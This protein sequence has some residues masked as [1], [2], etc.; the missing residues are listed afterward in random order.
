MSIRSEVSQVR[1]SCRDTS[2]LFLPVSMNTPEWCRWLLQGSNQKSRVNKQTC[3]SLRQAKRYSYVSS[4]TSSVT[5]EANFFNF[6]PKGQGKLGMFEASRT[7]IYGPL[8]NAMS[9]SL[10]RW[11]GAWKGS[12]NY[13]MDWRLEG[14]KQLF[15]GLAPGRVQTTIPW[16]GAWKGSNNYSMDWRLEGFKQLFHGIAPGR[17]QTTIPWTGAWKGS[18]NYSM[19][20]RLEGFKQLFHGLAPGR[21]QTTIP[22]TGAW[23]G[24]NNYSMDWRLEGFKQLFHGMAPGRVQ[25]TIPW[26][27]A[28][29]GSNNYSMDWRLE[30]FK[31]LFHGM[32]VWRCSIRS[33]KLKLEYITFS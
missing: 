28:W 5:D 7:K 18:N 23:K 25:T 13:S 12:N 17:V 16:T 29:K 20:W 30:G 10:R 21:V 31:Q 2:P 1:I 19:D 14:F 27:G 4:M 33:H 6:T 15:H 32:V 24:S 11:T 26:T 9:Y 22:W 3:A 8:Q